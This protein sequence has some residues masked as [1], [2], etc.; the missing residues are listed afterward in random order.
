MSES[1][2]SSN[3]ESN[4]DD[5][6]SETGA[7]KKKSATASSLGGITADRFIKSGKEKKHDS[8]KPDTVWERLS[9]LV[10]EGDKTGKQ[11]KKTDIF[12]TSFDETEAID[13]P[14]PSEQNIDDAALKALHEI[15]PDTPPVSLETL[16]EGESHEAVRQYTE[17]R[18]EQVATE[19]SQEL[20]GSDESVETAANLAFLRSMQEQIEDNPDQSV[21]EMLDAAER[22]ALSIPFTASEFRTLDDETQRENPPESD[23]V[24]SRNLAKEIEPEAESDSKPPEIP[25]AITGLPENPRSYRKEHDSA[26][27]FFRDPPQYPR[28]EAA[29]PS[30]VTTYEAAR[31]ERQAAASGL[32]M[33]GLVGYMVG[34]RKGRTR[35]EKA[36]L[37]V[38]K[39]LE[40]QIRKLHETVALKEESIRSKATA[41]A[42]MSSSLTE[43]SAPIKQNVE[44]SP[45]VYNSERPDYSRRTVAEREKSGG[46][47]HEKSEHIGRM[48][49]E[50][51]VAAN[52]TIERVRESDAS[53]SVKKKGVE[54]LN[55]Q[56]LHKAS[57]DVKISG[58][59]L[60][61]LH[62]SGR[63]NENAIR[64]I[65]A[66]HENGGDVSKVLSYELME[67]E[68]R[69]EKDPLIRAADA[70]KATGG[71]A[72]VAALAVGAV[73]A[74]LQ[75]NPTKNKPQDIADGVKVS[76]AKP[77]PDEATL[78]ELRSRQMTEIA[79]LTVLAIVAVIV[80]L[81]LL[82]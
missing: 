21:S 38:Q 42:I 23:S 34:R 68:K 2:N 17:A 75:E 28:A 13:E 16:S 62:D 63:L 55:Q 56:E 9:R 43:K 19:A 69:F 48:V 46:Y 5:D 54:N 10:D 53:K 15:N 74:P 30:M 76:S 27:S 51:P 71:G 50:S 40:N 35:T 82:R 8:D 1:F 26:D 81:L 4:D 36:L 12:S 18:V 58:L 79:G 78:R 20:E 24:S 39:K 66:V 52:A 70:S 67:Q 57:G 7:S 80:V 31:R 25:P 72:A 41:Q 64:R 65:L 59:S 14:E 73:V 3:K 60:R 22:Q 47:A 49:L 37:P 45:K 11:D 61:E 29:T 32:V 33:G 77:R 44:N 6:D